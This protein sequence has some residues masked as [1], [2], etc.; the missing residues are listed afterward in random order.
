MALFRRPVRF[1]SC[2]FRRVRIAG[3]D[4]ASVVSIEMK[5][6][7][8]W[9]FGFVQFT[10][11]GAAFLA[12]LIQDG[13]LLGVS[14]LFLLPGSLASIPVYKHLHP[15]FGVFLI[16]SSVAVA[17]NVLLFALVLNLLGRHSGHRKLSV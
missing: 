17:T 1:C 3:Y 13:L 12:A 11:V 2:H 16:P 15:G 14:W 7:S 9:I 5:H 8:W 4:T 6:K 10:G